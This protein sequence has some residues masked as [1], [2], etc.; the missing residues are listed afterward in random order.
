MLFICGPAHG[1]HSLMHVYQ[2][3]W[4]GLLVLWLAKIQPHQ[5]MLAFDLTSLKTLMTF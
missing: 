3:E 4:K 5:I 2:W 1:A